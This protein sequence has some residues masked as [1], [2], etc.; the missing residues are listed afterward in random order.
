MTQ[1]Q[2]KSEFLSKINEAANTIAKVSIRSSAN[3]IVTSNAFVN[4]F[5]SINSK[6]EK[7]KEKINKILK[8]E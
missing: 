5:D 3:Y 8:D 6:A 2:L 1:S 7:R 4:Y